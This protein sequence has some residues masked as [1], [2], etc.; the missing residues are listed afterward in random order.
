M[1]QRFTL[2][3]FAAGTIAALLCLATLS[4]CTGGE[5]SKTAGESS[6]SAEKTLEFYMVD[7]YVGHPYWDAIYNGAQAAAEEYGVTINRVGPNAVNVDEQLKYIETAIGAHCDGI[8]TSAIVPDSFIGVINEAMGDGIPVVTI[9]ADAPDSDRIAYV[10]T[11][12]YDAGYTAGEAMVEKLG[13]KGKVALL[14]GTIDQ[15]SLIDRMDGFK[16]ALQENAPE[17]KIVVTESSDNDLTKATEKTNSILAAYPDVTGIFCT[18]ASDT[19]GAGLTAQ[20]MGLD[21]A[22]LC[23]IGFDDLEDELNLI[24][25]GNVYGTIVQNTFQ[26]GYGGV[27]KLVEICTG[28]IPAEKTEGADVFNTGVTLVTSD[29]IDTYAANMAAGK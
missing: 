26:I 18:T 20:E 3:R 19:Q 5:S 21:T 17:M 27:E 25:S 22:S 15:Q 24:R 23:I 28:E 16:A 11:S 9:D 7:P 2:Q 29:N 1:K 6:T 10:G 12:N 8:F 4:G 13:G 14:T